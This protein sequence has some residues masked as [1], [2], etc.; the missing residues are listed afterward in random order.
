MIIEIHSIV[1][2]AGTALGAIFCLQIAREYPRRS[3]LQVA[4]LLLAGFALCALARHLIEGAS[5]DGI[6]YMHAYRHLTI[7]VSLLLLLSGMLVMA[8]AFFETGLGFSIT[9]LDGVAVAAIFAVLTVILVMHEHLSE[10]R[11]PLPASRYLQL[12]A[13]VVIAAA[14]AVSV[15]LHRFSVQMGGGKLAITMRLI[16]AHITI[17]VLLVLGNVIFGD[18]ILAHRSAGS[19]TAVLFDAAVWI[20]TGAA[21][22]RTRMLRVAQR[23]AEPCPEDLLAFTLEE[24]W[25]QDAAWTKT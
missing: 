4:W 12:A 14:A 16:I 6:A 23:Q 15:V 17:R 22:Y 19:A 8:R 10:A 18:F 2:E 20:F 5:L 9:R 24:P 11:F 21:F 7:L 1:R 25:R 3:M 13:Q